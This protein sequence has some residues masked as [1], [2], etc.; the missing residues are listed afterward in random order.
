[1]KTKLSQ[2]LAHPEM[3]KRIGNSERRAVLGSSFPYSIYYS[4]DV[5][6]KIIE[7]RG[8]FHQHRKLEREYGINEPDRL[9][10]IR[11]KKRR[12]QRLEELGALERKKNKSKD[13][14]LER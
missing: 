3:F 7:I 2:I 5:K 14:G 1:M 4:V 8:V 11:F 6:N 9:R 12:K 13:R 10:E